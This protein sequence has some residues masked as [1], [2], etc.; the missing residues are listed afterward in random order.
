MFIE[1]HSFPY[2]APRAVCCL[3]LGVVFV[4]S[5]QAYLQ[6]MRQGDRDATAQSDDDVSDDNGD[7]G[8]DNDVSEELGKLPKDMTR[9]EL[10]D[11]GRLHPEIGIK[12][13]TKSSI[14]RKAIAEYEKKRVAMLQMK[15]EERAKFLKMRASMKREDEK[16]AAQE[17]MDRVP[18][19]REYGHLYKLNQLSKDGGR[20][21]LES[22]VNSSKIINPVRSHARLRPLPPSELRG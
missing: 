14:I 2:V 8:S 3:V 15:K 1:F 21:V 18:F 13:S 6:N 16:R 11:W 10:M 12:N 5:H 22:A 7:G 20:I 19:L 4:K 17:L 9:L